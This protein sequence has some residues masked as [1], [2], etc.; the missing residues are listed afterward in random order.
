MNIIKNIALQLNIK[1]TQITNTL[2][3]LSEGNTVPFI[4]RYRKEITGGL[5][6]EIIRIIDE[7][8]QYQLNLSKRKEDVKRLIAVQDKLTDE[9][10]DA[11]D[12]CEKL[13]EVEDLYRPYQQK[14]KTRASKA[15]NAGL[16]PL[17]EIILNNEI[18]NDSEIELYICDE[19]DTLENVMQGVKDIIAEIVSDDAN[20][21]ARVRKE[22]YEYG[23]IETK[24]KKDADDPQKIYALYYDKQEKIKTIAPHRIMAI[25]R[26]ENE[27]I[28]NVK[29]LFNNEIVENI[30]FNK[31]IKYRHSNKINDIKE[32][33]LDG[34]TRLV[35]PSVERE[36]RNELTEIAHEKSIDIFS[37]NLEKLLLQPPLKN[38]MILGVD[39]AYRTGCKLAVI[40]EVSKLID[41]SVIYPHPPIN[42][43]SEA[44]K[45]ILDI[46]K[47]YPIEIIAIGNG[48]ASRETEKF[49]A[50]VINEN[51]LSVQFTI[52]SEA[53]A[54]VYSAST[55]AKEEFPALSVEQRS[56]ISI[57]RRVIDPLSELIKIDPK[58]IG[59]GQYQH[60]LPEKRLTQRL[61]F[62]VEKA[63]NKVGVNI[64]QASAKLL[65]NVS[66]LS[67]SAANSIVKYREEKGKIQN[68]SEIKKI[69]KIGAK[70][71]TQAIG[72]LRVLDSNNCLDATSIHPESYTL[73]NQILAHFNINDIFNK[74]E[75][76][77]LKTANIH[78]LAKHYNS[79]VYTIQDI[80]N[81][82]I[83]GLRDYREQFDAPILKS[84][85][86][87]IQDLKLN[88]ILQGVV[89]NVV[90]FG[91]F[92]DIG[93]KN[94][95]LIHIS[96]FNKRI[97]H[98]SEIVSV[99]DI[100]EVEIIDIDLE[101]NKVSLKFIKKTNN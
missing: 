26:G 80:I 9:L 63:V 45:I 70:T 12:Q 19:Y 99:G 61:D 100:I 59:V 15:I 54:S 66:G 48:T 56:A 22:M 96:K 85:I 53:G 84:S 83:N 1:E 74:D 39:P 78:E 11:I 91:S 27:K 89:R 67:A 42:K 31:T 88:D 16:K 34:L 30:A 33:I 52:V 98:P 72:F 69:P 14:R 76:K 35:Y 82:I 73:A 87:T 92:I 10:R 7:T 95:A 71:Y 86:L 32:A 5:D 46:L 94:D 50:D 8:Y 44:K 29:I 75:T 65:Q 51:Q 18:I 6:E 25:N 97:K 47:K 49:I 24:I 77:I 20:I 43:V 41:I 37:L 17:A 3:L 36:V 64:N 13:I 81:A 21:R 38:K 58:S 55:L 93:L 60:D 68:R 101:K 57:A 28:L 23:V 79:D 4:A 62:T 2:N 40:D 90:D